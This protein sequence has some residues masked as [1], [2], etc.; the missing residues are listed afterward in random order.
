MVHS[1]QRAVGRS[2]PTCYHLPPSP[3]H[4]T[5]AAD[6]HSSTA[7]P[8]PQRDILL[9][10]QAAPLLHFASLRPSELQLR[11]EPARQRAFEESVKPLGGGWCRLVVGVAAAVMVVVVVAAVAVAVVV[12]HVVVVVVVVIIG[13]S[14]S[15]V[16]S[17]SRVAEELNSTYNDYYHYYH[18]CH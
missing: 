5:S 1:P 7:L 2:T 18:Y 10:W 6:H 13:S 15:S 16:L 14:R 4:A 8:L 9:V 3:L 17:I 11:F 12:V